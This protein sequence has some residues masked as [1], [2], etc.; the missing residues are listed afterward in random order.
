MRGRLFDLPYGFPALVVPEE[1]VYAVGTTDY[2]A[3]AEQQHRAEAGARELSPHWGTVHG[4]LL[5]FDDPEERLPAL[6]GL[7]GFYPDERSFYRRVLIPATL[8][9]TGTSTPTWTYAVESTSGVYLP[10][11]R[12]PAS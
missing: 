3:N 4:E 2:L 1:D 9:D 12:W 8:V 5:A 6:D 11:G 7:E 10:G